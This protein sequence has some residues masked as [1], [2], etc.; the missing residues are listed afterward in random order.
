[1]NRRQRTEWHRRHTSPFPV[2]AMCTT[3]VSTMIAVWHEHTA[4]DVVTP[5]P[6]S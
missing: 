5:V 2:F 3:A 4:R 6:G 1:M